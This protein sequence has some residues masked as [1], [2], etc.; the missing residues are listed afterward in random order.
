MHFTRFIFHYNDA[1]IPVIGRVDTMKITLFRDFAG[2][3]L[4]PFRIA[5]DHLQWDPLIYYWI[6]GQFH[7]FVLSEQQRGL[8][9]YYW[10]AGLQS[11]AMTYTGGVGVRSGSKF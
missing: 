4:P 8:M 11:L 6:T 10:L 2:H 5:R 7:L 1:I 3:C 9:D